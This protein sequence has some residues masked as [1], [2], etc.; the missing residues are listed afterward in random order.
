ME[1]GAGPAASSWAGL[2]C[3]P[4][5]SLQAAAQPLS[6][7]G[8]LPH[9]GGYA[10]SLS[11]PM[12]DPRSDPHEALASQTPTCDARGRLCVKLVGLTDNGHGTQPLA[13]I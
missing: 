3:D 6:C 11:K 9:P 7:L 12:M 1:E 8:P 2:R 5:S 13:H 4:P 10:A